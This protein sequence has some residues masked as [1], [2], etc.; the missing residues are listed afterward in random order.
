MS[1]VRVEVDEVIERPVE[2]VFE[3]A[4]DLSHYSDWMP[5]TGVFKRSSQTSNG[6][7]GLGTTFIDQ[8]RMGT[9]RG[10]IVEFE[11]PSRVVFEETLRWFRSP[12]V[13]ARLRYE[14]VPVPEGTAV[15]HVAESE[16]HGIFRVMRPMVIIIGRGERRRTVRA[17]KKSLESS[18]SLATA[19][20]A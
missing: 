3:R 13:E 1:A 20:A 12:V 11:R 8:G 10:Q 4:I 17:L 7:V 15:H 16:L 2:Q 5:R 9:F 6:P 18:G 14:F 19:A